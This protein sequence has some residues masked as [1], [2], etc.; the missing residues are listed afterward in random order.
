[1]LVKM[2]FL[3]VIVDLSLLCQELHDI[4]VLD[5]SEMGL[6]DLRV[7]YHQTFNFTVKYLLFQE[8]MITSVNFSKLVLMF[9]GLQMVDLRHNPFDCK[10]TKTAVEV[11]SNC[12]SITYT[13]FIFGSTSTGPTS[14]TPIHPSSTSVPKFFSSTTVP[15]TPGH[16]FTGSN[17]T[18]LTIILASI[19]PSCAFV[20]TLI[21]CVL[22]I[23]V[24]KYYRRRSNSEMQQFANPLWSSGGVKTLF[25]QESKL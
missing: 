1:M 23:K 6:K 2:F 11:L 13:S 10:I 19:V 14:A 21:L 5:C 16:S 15:S 8:N 20:I 12:S 18:R 24:R 7:I 22:R 17:D 3:A 9:S 25:E 4:N